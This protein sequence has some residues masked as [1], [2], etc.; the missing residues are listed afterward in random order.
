MYFGQLA[1]VGGQA[2]AVAMA[3]LEHLALAGHH[4][5]S[6]LRKHCADA[7]STPRYASREVP[8]QGSSPVARSTILVLETPFVYEQNRSLRP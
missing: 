3:G 5:S 8:V 1:Q 7:H 2:G 4:F 6:F